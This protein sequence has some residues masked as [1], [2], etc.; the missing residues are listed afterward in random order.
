MRTASDEVYALTLERGRN[1]LRQA[2]FLIVPVP[3]LPGEVR[4]KRV[5]ALICEHQ[6]KFTATANLPDSLGDQV[7]RN[8]ENLLCFLKM[9]ESKLAA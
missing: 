2:L 7:P 8:S 5:D 3:E 4:T 9:P 1:F 6:R